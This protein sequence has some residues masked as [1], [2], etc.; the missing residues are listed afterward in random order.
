MALDGDIQLSAETAACG[1]LDGRH[2]VLRK[3]QHSGDFSAVIMRV[4]RGA[5][6]DH[7]SVFKAGDA[8]VR[9]NEHMGQHGRLI[10]VFYDHIAVF[11]GFVHIAV[12]KMLFLMD[13]CFTVHLGRVLL[14][15]ALHGENRLV[16]LIL[17]LDGLQSVADKFRRFGGH[18]SDG[19]AIPADFVIHQNRLVLEDDANPVLA[20][21]ILACQHTHHA[22]NLQS[23][24][25]VKV[26]D[27]AMADGAAENATVEHVRQLHIG[28]KLG[29][30]HNLLHGV[31]FDNAF[32]QDGPVVLT[33][34]GDIHRAFFLYSDFCFFHSLTP[35]FASR[36]ISTALMILLYPVQRQ[37]L[38]DMARRISSSVASGFLSS[39]ALAERTMPGVQ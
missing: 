38:P 20:G 29:A 23:G 10:I 34:D 14:G 3:R 37:R 31:L 9:L 25:R 33:G 7:L 13:V 2:A 18:H 35:P 12:L 5:V 22:W 21:D 24:G 16:F 36:A 30:A 26:L 1:N 27:S 8:G 32:A 4:L 39:S 19:V 11:E 15:G 6:N 28:R 17:H